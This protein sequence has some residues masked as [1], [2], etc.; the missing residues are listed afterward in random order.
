MVPPSDNPMVC[1]RQ[2]WI[3]SHR[4]GMVAR[5]WAECDLINVLIAGTRVKTI[6]SHLSVTDLATLIGDG[7]VPAGG[8]EEN[9]PSRPGK[10]PRQC[11]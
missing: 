4:A 9:R 5:F 1:R 3:G 8:D 7:A 2:F 11:G 6:R 10:Q